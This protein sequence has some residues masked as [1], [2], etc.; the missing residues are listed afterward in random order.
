[1]LPLPKISTDKGLT[2]KSTSTSEHE[3]EHE[4]E[5]SGHLVGRGLHES[6]QAIHDNAQL[7]KVRKTP[8]AKDQ[9]RELSI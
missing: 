8:R 9:K 1:M 6:L 7:E 3:H 2:S 5:R 4:H